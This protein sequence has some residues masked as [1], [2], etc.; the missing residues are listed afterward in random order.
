[1]ASVRNLYL[2]LCLIT[3][4]DVRNLKFGIGTL[5]IYKY[6]ICVKQIL[7]FK[8]YK[9]GDDAKLEVLSDNKQLRES[10]GKTKL[11]KPNAVRSKWT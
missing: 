1:M 6:K 10:K 8:K 11:S 2:I 5:Y 9:Y 3:I 7:Y 4:L